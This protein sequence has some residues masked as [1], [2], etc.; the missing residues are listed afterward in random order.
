MDPILTASSEEIEA[1]LHHFTMEVAGIRAGRAN[2]SLIE[3]I[4]V[5]AYGGVMKLNE[6]G[7]ISAPQPTLLT[8]SVWDASILDNVIKAIQEANLGLNPSNEGIL[9]RLPI[10]SLTAERREEFIKLLHQKIEQARV[11]IRQIRGDFRNGWKKEQDNGQ[12]SEDE[13]FRRERLLQELVDKKIMEVEQ[14]GK[15]KEEALTQI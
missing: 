14:I 6:L 10:P 4:P 13:F 9:I 7:N 8:V 11:E 3:N 15:S 5:S 12:I 2:P 1:A